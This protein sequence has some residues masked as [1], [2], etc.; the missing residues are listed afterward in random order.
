M[1]LP[2]PTGSFSRHC[3][4]TRQGWMVQRVLGTIALSSLDVVYVPVAAHREESGNAE[5]DL[6][7]PLCISLMNPF[8]LR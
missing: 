4:T 6:D 8:M 5:R 2:C 3:N 1:E 7:F